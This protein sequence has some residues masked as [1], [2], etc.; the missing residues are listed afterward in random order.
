MCKYNTGATNN[1]MY[2]IDPVHVVLLN[3]LLKQKAKTE[4]NDF[5][6][7]KF[8]TKEHGKNCI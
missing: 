2:A 3:Q 7:D 8:V 5:Y 1:L 4:A 6:N